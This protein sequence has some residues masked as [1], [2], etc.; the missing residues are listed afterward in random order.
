MR[1]FL[2][3]IFALVMILSIVFIGDVVSSNNP[4]AAQAQTKVTVR[5]KRH[6]GV[7]SRTYRGG[8]WVYH[9]SAN[10]TRYVIHK[11]KRGTKWTYHKTKRGTKKVFHKVKKAVV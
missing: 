11:T 3:L 1:K 6:R 4:F 9:K 2:G 7:A 5:R 10:G 8:K